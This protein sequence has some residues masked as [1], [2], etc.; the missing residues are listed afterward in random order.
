MELKGLY[1]STPTLRVRF[2][3]KRK[4][5]TRVDDVDYDSYASDAGADKDKP[6]DDNALA[7]R[8]SDTA[9][10][11]AWA[12]THKDASEKPEIDAEGQK[13]TEMRDVGHYLV[14]TTNSYM[15]HHHGRTWQQDWV[16]PECA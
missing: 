4:R 3:D 2:E 8:E 12:S 11:L 14:Y 7:F 10:P 6:E 5:V 9:P 13:R 1:E 15:K 16:T